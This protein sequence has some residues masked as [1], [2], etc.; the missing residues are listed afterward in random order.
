MRNT[1]PEEWYVYRHTKLGT[2]EVFYIGIGCAKNYSRVKSKGSRSDWW[3]RYVKK[4]DFEG[5]ILAINLSLIEAC[6]LEQILIAY[7]RR[8]DCC[9][10]SLLNMTDGGEG[11]L[12]KKQSDKNKKEQSKRMK[13]K[14]AGE[15]NPMYGVIRESPFK[16]RTH[17]ESSKEALR[18]ER[19]TF[20][21][22][23]NPHSKKVINTETGIIYDC[24]K[25]ASLAIGFPQSTVTAWLN[26]RFK[27]K[28]NLMYL[29]K[30][31]NN[32]EF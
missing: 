32:G 6:E 4:Y 14:F 21:C 18:G 16:G 8:K 29:E 22:A 28:S 10:G 17:T 11:S 19:L 23:N 27:N 15:K 3:K 20:Q 31:L 5:E 2:S 1:N 24:V 7:Y 12:G 25:E 26:G 9:G 13:G 30:Y